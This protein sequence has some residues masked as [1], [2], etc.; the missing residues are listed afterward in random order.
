MSASRYMKKSR[1]RGG[2]HMHGEL[3]LEFGEI[4][5]AGWGLGYGLLI[6]E[7]EVGD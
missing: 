6:N 1:S 5:Y 7:A 3:G 4:A 2:F